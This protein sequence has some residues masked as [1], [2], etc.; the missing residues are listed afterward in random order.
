MPIHVSLSEINIDYSHSNQ[1]NYEC[2]KTIV[3]SVRYSSQILNEL[4]FVNKY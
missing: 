3:H 2:M 4:E 1:N